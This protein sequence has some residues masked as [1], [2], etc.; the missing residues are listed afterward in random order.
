MARVMADSRSGTTLF[1]TVDEAVL[2][3]RARCIYLRGC[4]PPIYNRNAVTKVAST[5]TTAISESSDANPS[6]PSTPHATALAPLSTAQSAR[7]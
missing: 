2:L 6:I 4:H 3:A 5:G 7:L 1:I